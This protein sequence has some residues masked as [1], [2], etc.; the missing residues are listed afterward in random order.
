MNQHF[1]QHIIIHW[2]LHESLALPSRHLVRRHLLLCLALCFWNSQIPTSPTV[3]FYIQILRLMMCNAGILD[4]IR[5]V[6]RLLGTVFILFFPLRKPK[7]D[8][9][10]WTTIKSIVLC[11]MVAGTVVSSNYREGFF[12]LIM[13][14]V[15]LTKTVIA[16]PVFFVSISVLMQPI[17]LTHEHKSRR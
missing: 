2:H 13:T 15:G 5:Q 14:V 10:V 6:M 4:M 9:F 1:I 3:R 7:R 17:P 11:T 12:F 8:F 16:L